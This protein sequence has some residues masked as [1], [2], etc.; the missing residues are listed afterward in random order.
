MGQPFKVLESKPS[1]FVTDKYL[2]TMYRNG[3]QRGVY[4]EK[5]RLMR[6][7]INKQRLLEQ[8]LEQKRK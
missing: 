7:Q 4:T 5:E 1:K 8:Q 2:L 3:G 6:E